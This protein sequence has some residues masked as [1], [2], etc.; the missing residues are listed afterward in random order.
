MDLAPMYIMG[1]L[2]AVLVSFAAFIWGYKTMQD[3]NDK[4]WQKQCKE[5]IDT[6]GKQTQSVSG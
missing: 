5:Q 3:Q 1:S 2:I 4:D 6:I